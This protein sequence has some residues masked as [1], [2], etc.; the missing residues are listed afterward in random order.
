M[1][2]EFYDGTLPKKNGGQ[3]YESYG[4]GWKIFRVL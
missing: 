1:K 2:V 4:T 3:E